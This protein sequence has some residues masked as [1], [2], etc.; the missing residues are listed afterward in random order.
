MSSLK[1]ACELKHWRLEALFNFLGN[2]AHISGRISSFSWLSRA[3]FFGQ[4]FYF[5]VKGI[6]AKNR[7]NISKNLA[8]VQWSGH[9][10]MLDVFQEEREKFENCRA[11]KK[12][13]H[14]FLEIQK[15]S[16]ENSTICCKTAIPFRILTDSR[17]VWTGIGT[18]SVTFFWR[19][20]EER[21]TIVDELSTNI[22]CARSDGN[23]QSH[24]CKHNMAR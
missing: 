5:S 15:E 24:L 21:V 10:Y 23:R 2:H 1:S 11:K 8:T 12:K 22:N 17:S 16:S 13:E 9:V 3:R 14:Y 20:P 19:A 18:L 4:Q 6:M 7:G